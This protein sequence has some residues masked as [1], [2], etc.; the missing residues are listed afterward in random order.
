MVLTSPIMTDNSLGLLIM[1]H[2]YIM[3]I[4]ITL[5]I[6]CIHSLCLQASASGSHSQEKLN[7]KGL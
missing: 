4:S 1:D 6:R 3:L 2:K 7:G 5:S